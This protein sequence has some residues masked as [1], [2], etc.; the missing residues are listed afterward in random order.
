VAG[1]T[2][3]ITQLSDGYLIMRKFLVSFIFSNGFTH[4]IQVDA[5]TGMLAVR[6]AHA[7]LSE[8]VN[9]ADAVEIICKEKV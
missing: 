3:H 4:E 7:K 6:N 8:T 1:D 9:L 5:I 2:S